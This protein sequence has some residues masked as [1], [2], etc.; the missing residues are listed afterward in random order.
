MNVFS[1]RIIRSRL[2]LTSE[3]GGSSN[4]KTHLELWLI[5]NYFHSDFHVLVVKKEN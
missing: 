4:W 5:L 2:F 1:C 3:H